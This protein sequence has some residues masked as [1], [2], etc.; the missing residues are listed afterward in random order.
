VREVAEIGV[1][2]ISAGPVL[3]GK[4]LERIREVAVG[5]LEY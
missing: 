4:A 3:H 5:L 1:A 2:R